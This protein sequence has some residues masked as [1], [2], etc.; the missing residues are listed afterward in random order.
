M[1]SRHVANM[2]TRAGDPN[3]RCCALYIEAALEDD[4]PAQKT[5]AGEK[6][7]KGAAEGAW[8]ALGQMAAEQHVD[9]LL[10]NLQHTSRIGVLQ[11]CR[12]R[13]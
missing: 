1:I 4:R 9:A 10:R 13:N 7:L 2:I 8:I 5:D 12:S 11:F 6:T 3:G